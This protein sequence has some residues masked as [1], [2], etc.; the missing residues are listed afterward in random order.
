MKAE[1][2]IYLDHAAT[3]P[4]DPRV[5]EAML[6]Y[7]AQDYG[8]PSSLHRVGQQAHEAI[9]SARNIVA[10]AL[11]ANPGEIVFTSCGTESDNL[12]IRGIA[13]G[14]QAAGKHI[15]TT[16]VEHHA[17][18]NTCLQLAERFGF[19]VTFLPVDARGLVDPDQVREAI[20]PETA[21]ISVMYA[22]N[23]VGSV[24]P[25]AE[26]GAI[27]REHEIP[28]HSDAVQASGQLSL[29]V[30]AL[31]LD[32]MSLSGHKF[33]APKG[34][35][36][37]YVREGLDLLP[38][39]TGGAQEHGL[40]AGT[41]NV[42]YIVGLAKALQLACDERECEVRRLAALRDRL[43]EGLTGNIGGCHLT[44]HPTQ[45]LPNSASFVFEGVDGEAIQI[46]LSMAGIASGTGSA[47]AS[48]EDAPSHV[49]AALGVEPRLAQGS[50]RLT[51]GRDTQEADIER[52]IAVLPPIIKDLRD[53]SPF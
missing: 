32:L 18:E 34:V 24:Q 12:A 28:F 52:V 6:P 25:I 22:N 8:N 29:D 42:P 1:E 10:E 43:I 26:I 38:A 36:V 23:E 37:L 15:I 3:T 19:E 45:R 21:L 17:V 16:H 33:Y 49:L 14:R 11:G 31:N 13:F 20:R 35:G 51:L 53:L 2:M 48:G 5:L 44:G 50:L 7:F 30:N 4:V 9:S 27:A 46:R 41:Q 39:Q 40:R 47:C